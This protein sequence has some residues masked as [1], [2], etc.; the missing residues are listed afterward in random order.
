MFL[1]GITLF[2]ISISL[3]AAAEP[4]VH[5]R[6]GHW[7][8]R[9]ANGNDVNLDAQRQAALDSEMNT[10]SRGSRSYWFRQRGGSW[11]AFTGRAS[12]TQAPL[13]NLGASSLTELDSRVDAA[14][15][16]AT[17]SAAP[18]AASTAGAPATGTGIP[19]S[20]GAPPTAPPGGYTDQAECLRNFGAA[21]GCYRDPTGKW[22]PSSATATGTRPGEEGYPPCPSGKTCTYYIDNQGRTTVATTCPTGVRC[23]TQA[24]AVTYRDDAGTHYR[25]THTGAC[26]GV[27]VPSGMQCKEVTIDEL[28]RHFFCDR[29][30]RACAGAQAPATGGDVAENTRYWTPSSRSG[31]IEAGG[32]IV[33]IDGQ[34]TGV[35][36]VVGDCPGGGILS[37]S[38]SKSLS[39]EMKYAEYKNYIRLQARVKSL[40]EGI[41]AGRAWGEMFSF[42]TMGRVPAD[43]IEFGW[44]SDLKDFLEGN[45]FG[46]WLA[47]RPEYSIC[48]I[49]PDVSDTVGMIMNTGGT[50]IGMWVKG[51]FT[52]VLGRPNE[53]APAE[54]YDLYL[55]KI[56]LSVMPSGLT[57]NSGDEDCADRIRFYVRLHGEGG[58]TQEIDFRQPGD[59]SDNQIDLQCDGPPV[60]YTGSSAIVWPARQQ[61]NK[62]CIEFQDSD[63]HDQIS[64]E[65]EDNNKLCA[66]LVE[67]GSPEDLGCSI[68]VG[69]DLPAVTFDCPTATGEQ[70]VESSGVPAATGGQGGFPTGQ[71]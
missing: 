24:D 62:V 1:L 4:A 57:A 28:Q 7:R 53:T 50:G 11:V 26:A 36:R 52:P 39:D 64:S 23:F 41:D 2:I 9:D 6:G 13:A 69:R 29:N 20:A 66:D 16:A 71:Y 55:Y 17:G 3:V 14:V 42:I 15:S 63:L 18:A 38:C 31:C 21:G 34:E 60:T 68:S 35:C 8:Y 46:A 51:E 22:H 58:V 30:D 59:P 43:W 5:Y 45:G 37:P 27:G 25:V 10:L 70:P 48:Y 65:L 47:G 56:T 67:S 33:S 40:Q 49:T 54:A 12:A 44:Q 61:F 19:P 32:N